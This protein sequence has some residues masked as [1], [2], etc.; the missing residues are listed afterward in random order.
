MNGTI[1]RVAYIINNKGKI[2]P[3]A[4]TLDLPSTGL[5]VEHVSTKPVGKET[6]LS[7]FGLA[8]KGCL[9]IVSLL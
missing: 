4:L 5:T 8:L 6:K 1:I 3:K 2:Q 7:L 9:A